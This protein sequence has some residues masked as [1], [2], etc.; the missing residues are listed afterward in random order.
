MFYFLARRTSRTSVDGWGRFATAPRRVPGAAAL[1]R[2][3]YYRSFTHS[4]IHQTN[5][6]TAVVGLRFNEDIVHFSLPWHWSMSY[7]RDCLWSSVD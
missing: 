2:Q 6:P 1:G 3:D 4:C 7:H 5:Q